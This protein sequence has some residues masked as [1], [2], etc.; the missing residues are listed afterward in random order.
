MSVA[1]PGLS[2]NTTTLL[3]EMEPALLTVPLNASVPPGGMGYAGQ[4]PVTRITGQLEQRTVT[5]WAQTLGSPQSSVANQVAVIICG[6]SALVTRP[7]RVTL[8]L[9]SEQVDIAGGGSKLQVLSHWTIL[10]SAHLR[11]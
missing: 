2:L 11:T 6:Q 5:V 9:L 7:A 10:L 3:K 4:F 1:G 8:T